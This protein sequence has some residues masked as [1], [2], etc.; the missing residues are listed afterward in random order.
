MQF[1]NLVKSGLRVSLTGL[2]P[3]HPLDTNGAYPL[4]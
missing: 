3:R 1:R 2:G 4:A